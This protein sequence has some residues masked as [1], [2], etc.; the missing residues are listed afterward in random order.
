MTTTVN[1]RCRLAEV[2][3][4]DFG[5]P[6]SEPLLPASIYRDRM[7]R[8]R[9]AMEERGYDHIVVWADREHS[10]N[11]AYLTG[12]DPRFEEAALVVGTS[13]DPAILVGNEC[14][15]LA[16]AA[17]LTMRLV[18]FQDLSLPGQPRSESRPLSE[19]LSDEGIGPAGRVGVVGWKTYSSRR[20]ME[21]PAFLIDELRRSTGPAGLVENA[22]DVLI[23]P[24]DG[25][26]VTNEVEQLA[27]FEWAACHTSS[28]VR[29]VLTG[30]RLGMT[31][32]DCA[33]LL[34]WNGSPLSCHLMLTAGPKARY[35]LFSPGDR[36]LERGDPF[37]IAF[38][39]WGALNCR[40]GFLVEDSTELPEGAGDYVDRLVAPYFAAVADWYGALHVGQ[41]GGELQAVVDRHLG[42]SFFGVTL[43]PGHQLHLDEWVNSPVFPGS[44]IELRSGTA[45]QCDIIPATGTPY[46]TTNIEDG[47]ALA[48]ESLRAEVS[49]AYPDAWS[50]I[51]A[52]RHF[53]IE[54]LGIDLHPDVLPFS[55]LAAFL[56][57]LLLR[58]DTAMTFA[59]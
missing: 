11:I 15:G 28:S 51:Q 13:S 52:R 42:D 53:M 33:Q 25:L 23:D 41:T 47:V 37:T 19:I 20:S 26:R 18:R 34:M 31:E 1:R 58:S 16:E 6:S 14:Y 21:A 36:P 54:T 59:H 22:C 17:P 40:A 45:L 27:A 9:S 57:P 29:R 56:P 38:G 39:I 3:L 8:L 5:M 49:T 7:E 50:R 48:D 32:R 55:N 24:I 46:F 12:F 30:L 35:G 2:V 4:P 44:R 10:A 43:N